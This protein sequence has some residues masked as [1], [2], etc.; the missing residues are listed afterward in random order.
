VE[1]LLNKIYSNL[2]DNNPFAVGDSTTLHHS[3]NPEV[4]ETK[5]RFQA[6]LSQLQSLAAGG[7]LPFTLILRD[8][9]GNSFI[10]APIGSF[11]PPEMD[12]NIEIIDFQRSFEEVCHP[13]LHWEVMLQICLD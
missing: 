10:S 7:R 13:L 2:R 6:F 11:L 12:T 9:L 3:N 1:G 4:S 8:P 5:Q